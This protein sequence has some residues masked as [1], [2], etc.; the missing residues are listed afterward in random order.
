MTFIPKFELIPQ[1][2]KNRIVLRARQ[3]NASQAAT[4]FHEEVKMSKKGLEYQLRRLVVPEKK[5]QELPEQKR[6]WNQKPE[7]VA[8]ELSAEELSLLERLKRGEAG[9]SDVSGVVAAKVFEKMLQ[10]PDDF[11]FI[12]FFRTELLRQKN[13]ENQIRD[14]WAREII[15]RM[16]AGKLPPREITC[17]KCGHIQPTVKDSLVLEPEGILEGEVEDD[18]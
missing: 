12:D 13:E 1:E 2:L 6:R 17:E 18:V 8:K 5:E 14:K 9:I 15:N 3:T 11:R 16:F 10:F 7:R 4:E